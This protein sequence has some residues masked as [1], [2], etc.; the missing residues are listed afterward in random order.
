M[1]HPIHAADASPTIPRPSAL[2][3]RAYN[4]PQ[5]ERLTLSNGLRLVVARVAK[6][7]LV[8]VL[9]LT[10][11]GSVS[12]PRGREGLAQLTARG[13]VEGTETSDG[14]ALSERFERL[15]TA[16]DAA[17]D[18]DAATM[19][20]TTVAER[21]S[22][23]LALFAEVLTTPSFPEREIERLR[24]LLCWKSRQGLRPSNHSALR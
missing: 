7:P 18:W 24:F 8:T 19:S 2:P 1:S 10:E 14:I 23:A 16:V 5:F 13:L 20:L 4:F 9:S 3:A 22:E 17:A 11:A 6:L 15:G 21:L 12:D